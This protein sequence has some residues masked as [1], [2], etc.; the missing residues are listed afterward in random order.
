MPWLRAERSENTSKFLL[1]DLLMKRNASEAG[2]ADGE[3]ARLGLPEEKFPG[4]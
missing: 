2:A 4:Q 3:G 1:A